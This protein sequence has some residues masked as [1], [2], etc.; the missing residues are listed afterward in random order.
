MTCTE[1]IGINP[2]TKLELSVLELTSVESLPSALNTAGKF[3]TILIAWDATDVSTD[4]IS[5]FARRLIDAGGVYFCTWGD[6]CE[7]VHDIID[8]ELVGDGLA[9]D[10]KPHVMTSW[11]DDDSL[12][13]AIWFALYT[14]TPIRH[15]STITVRSSRF[16]LVVETGL[17]KFGRRSLIPNDSQTKC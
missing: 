12:A 4:T 8:E 9:L 1:H 6:N 13:E 17:E 15:T 3:A 14:A 5:S 16:P 10:V 11:N 2:T 7:L